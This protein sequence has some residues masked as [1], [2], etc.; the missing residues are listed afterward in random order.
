[1]SNYDYILRNNKIIKKQDLP[2]LLND[3]GFLYGYG[4]FESILVKNSF[5]ILLKDHLK[6]LTYSANILD[7]EIPFSEEELRN[8]IQALIEKNNVLDAVLN[9]YLT[10]GDRSIGETHLLFGESHIIALLRP[11]P[12]PLPE[13]GIKVALREESFTRARVDQL[14]TMS[15]MK[16]IMEKRLA[17]P[18]DDVILYSHEGALLESPTA[19]IFII[20]DDKILTPESKAI[21]P[22]IIRQFILES[23]EKLGFN[24]K[25]S[26]LTLDDLETAQEVFLTNSIRGVIP[27]ESLE[28]TPGVFSGP[29]THEL[30]VKLDQLLF[31]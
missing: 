14:K 1:M 30:K 16:N 26:P 23:G 19:N 17:E 25:E 31:I 12:S 11:L 24:V 3:Y 7:I 18:F 28:N 20:K 8:N 15:Y 22:G 27:V 29:I 4:L 13:Q 2:C 5:P 6:R 10:P 21:L 9:I